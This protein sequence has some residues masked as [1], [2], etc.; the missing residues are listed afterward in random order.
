MTTCYDKE[1]DGSDD[2]DYGIK[3]NNNDDEDSR[4]LIIA[5]IMITI[6]QL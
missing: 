3:N 1:C 5:M 2:N 6:E 4:M